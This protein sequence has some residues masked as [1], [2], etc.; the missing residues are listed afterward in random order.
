[1]DNEINISDKDI[2]LEKRGLLTSLMKRRFEDNIYSIL[3]KKSFPT[4]QD[5]DDM[6]D[7]KIRAY[8]SE[9]KAVDDYYSAK[10]RIL[11]EQEQEQEEEDDNNDI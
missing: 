10:V 8:F 5:L 1:M 9:M 11:E 2:E 3:S 7:P 6:L 4:M